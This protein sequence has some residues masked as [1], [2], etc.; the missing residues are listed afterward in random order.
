MTRGSARVAALL[1]W[2]L[3]TA[4]WGCAKLQ[5]E[6]E[7]DDGSDADS[8]SDSDGDSDA[9]TDADAD[10]DADSDADADTDSDSDADT[11]S[12]ADADT[13][14]DSDSDGDGDSDSDG[15]SDTLACPYDCLSLT[16][17]NLSGGSV[18]PLFWC[19]GTNVCCNPDPDTDTNPVECVSGLC[20]D[21]GQYLGADVVCDSGVEQG[22]A[23]TGCGGDTQQRTV[24]QHCTGVSPDC[25]G[26]TVT[27]D[28]A[29]LSD[30]TAEQICQ[31]DGDSVACLT[32]PYGCVTDQCEWVDWIPL[33][34]GLYQMG[35]AAGGTD[36][37]PV[38]GVTVAGFAI[39]A[40]EVTVLDYLRCRQQGG[41]ATTP[42]TA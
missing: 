15:D 35:S 4:A 39:G 7:D 36:E 22:C 40:S 27:G 20:C 16:L 37:L 30:C 34:G 2:A 18:E 26:N 42:G 9:D 41:C 29:L 21:E 28:W 5:T 24:E 10:S 17:C 12:D 38:H 1:A 6:S 32:C 25:T 23:S 19:A 14:S 31:A 3:G 33:T 8:D 11:D 13:D